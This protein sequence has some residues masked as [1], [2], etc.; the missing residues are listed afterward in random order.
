MP[1]YVLVGI[2]PL[3]YTL[4]ACIAKGIRFLSLQQAVGFDHVVHIAT[5]TSHAMHQ[6]RVGIHPDV[7]LHTKI[8][9]VALLALMH[10]GVSCLAF[11][12]G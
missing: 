11:I 3:V 5:A 1:A 9:L 7:R 12:L 10:L 6:P 2:G 8:L 4:I